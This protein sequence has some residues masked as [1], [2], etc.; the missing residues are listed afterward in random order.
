MANAILIVFSAVIVTL[1]FNV[2][3]ANKNKTISN[4][5]DK[6]GR[7]MDEINTF[8]RR[9]MKFEILKW[10]ISEK[11]SVDIADSSYTNLTKQLTN[12]KKTNERVQA[13]TMEL[14]ALIGTDLKRAFYRQYSEHPGLVDGFSDTEIVEKKF[15]LFK[16]RAAKTIVHDAPDGLCMYISRAVMFYIRRMIADISVILKT[17][18]DVDYQKVIGNYCLILERDVY[19]DNGIYLINPNEQTDQPDKESATGIQ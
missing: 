5:Y 9:E 2:F 16:Y 6:S 7:Y 4:V 11:D 10:I 18:E 15:L 19:N 1:A 8:I 12:P 13:I 3:M 17:G 14:M